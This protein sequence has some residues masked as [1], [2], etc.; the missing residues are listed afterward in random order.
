[1]T[2][3][4]NSSQG[5]LGLRISKVDAEI[6]LLACLMHLTAK[7]DLYDALSLVAR[8]NNIKRLGHALARVFYYHE[9]FPFEEL[10]TKD[11][12]QL[13]Q[14]VTNIVTGPWYIDAE[15]GS[16]KDY[17]KVVTALFTKPEINPL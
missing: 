17:Q 6:S 7:G 2:T 9:C 3:A 5:Q 11:Y 15:L 13:R 1:M 12:N 16:N 14:I 10:E 4:V 8:R